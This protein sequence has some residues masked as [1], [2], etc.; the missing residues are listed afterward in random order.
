MRADRI[1]AGATAGSA[2]A[3]VGAAWA[4]AITRMGATAMGTGSGLGSLWLF[5]GTWAAMMAAM[6]LPAAFPALVWSGQLT[7]QR[8]SSVPGMAAL[9]TVGY[10]A[11]WELAGI[12]GFAA[13]REITEA[14]AAG[15]WEGAA[16]AGTAVAAAGLYQLTSVKRACL[17]RCR[18][19]ERLA[20]NAVIAG[21][22]YRA[23]CLGSS[24][25]LM[26]VLL[27]L[28]AMSITW[29]VVVTAL[30]FAER[31]PRFGQALVIPV[32]LGL[33][34]LGLWVAVD[35]SLVPGLMPAIQGTE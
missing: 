30:V 8:A 29:M 19:R 4:L 11:V 20:G 35:P 16:A 14:S 13:Y 24:A 15:R 7:A 9:F 23:N 1:A 25:G 34:G 27:A 3:V 33:I 6:M 18:S 22:R 12:A 21:L 26:L 32:A 31:V 10:L 28:G 5:A 17:R 2:L